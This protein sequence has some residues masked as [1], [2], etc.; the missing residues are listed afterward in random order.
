[1]KNQFL[2]SPNRLHYTIYIFLSKT[3]SSNSPQNKIDKPPSLF[4]LS[5]R[6]SDSGMGKGETYAAGQ[7]WLRRPSEHGG[8][9]RDGQTSRPCYGIPL[10]LCLHLAVFWRIVA[11][12]RSPLTVGISARGT[13]RRT[14][15]L[16][17]RSSRAVGQC[18]SCVCENRVLPSNNDRVPLSPPPSST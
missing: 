10:R 11:F 2:D 7:T 17:I 12:Q 4:F 9:P 1:M 18:V 3:D 14:A 8:P 13:T 15:L 6:R 5:N 16:L